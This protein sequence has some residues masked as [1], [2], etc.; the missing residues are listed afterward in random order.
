MNKLIIKK[1]LFLNIILLSVFLSTRYVFAEQ[2]VAPTP[3]PPHK[4]FYYIESTEQ[5]GEDSQYNYF[6]T[7]KKQ[8]GMPCSG[9]SSEQIMYEANQLSY[10]ACL[11]LQAS[12]EGLNTSN[13]TLLQQNSD[14][15]NTI[16]EQN[17]SCNDNFALNSIY[18]QNTHE[19]ACKTGYVTYDA[20][21]A[22]PNFYDSIGFTSPD[23]IQLACVTIKARQDSLDFI[24]KKSNIELQ[25]LY[26]DADLTGL[27]KTLEETHN[28]IFSSASSLAYKKIK[29][30]T[31]NQIIENINLIA[32]KYSG[33]PQDMQHYVDFLSG[34]Q[35]IPKLATKEHP[36]Y[37]IF[38]LAK[39]IKA[40]YPQYKNEDDI[41][42][43]KK[44]IV[45]YPIFKDRIIMDATSVSTKQSITTTSDSSNKQK[46]QVLN[47][48]KSTTDS[49]VSITDKPIKIKWYQR[50]FN[51]FM[52]K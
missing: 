51:W 47:E 8:V 14:Y 10:N 50:I 41:T 5:V 33:S 32:N 31:A 24:M 34:Y 3:P 49:Q 20:N 36:A 18:D 26:P 46:E 45:K 15:S 19:C 27:E 40:N 4:C 6:Q 52:G 9:E 25:K 42:L 39:T 17:K 21:Y 12:R 35:S 2:C 11:Q 37:P 43:V 48:K 13:K 1:V 23:N 28:K 16:Q 44:F 7:T 38:D 30:L 29:P 22:S